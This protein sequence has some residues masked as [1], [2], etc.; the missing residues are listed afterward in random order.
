MKNCVINNGFFF[1]IQSEKQNKSQILDYEIHF[2][3]NKAYSKNKHQCMPLECYKKKLLQGHNIKITYI[4]LFIAKISINGLHFLI[5]S[6]YNVIQTCDWLSTTVPHYSVWLVKEKENKNLVWLTTCIGRMCKDG[7]FVIST[8]FTWRGR[9]IIYGLFIFHTKKLT[10][11][12]NLKQT[13]Q[14]LI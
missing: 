12:T 10:N 8:S 3:S 9:M 4:S 2:S 11:L 6:L 13:I 1:I 5:A 7:H 14:T